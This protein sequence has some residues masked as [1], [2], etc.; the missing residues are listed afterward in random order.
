MLSLKPELIA[1]LDVQAREAI[2]LWGTAAQFNMVI[3]E[4][5]ELLNEVAKIHRNQ[6]NWDNIL[7]ES[8][9]TYIMMTEVFLMYDEALVNAMLEKKLT[10]FKANLE[11]SKAKKAEQDAELKRRMNDLPQ[12]AKSKPENVVSLFPDANKYSGA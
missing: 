11:R 9:D 3:E 6:Q 7:E 4:T 5:S 12:Y 1:Q 2:E 8:V 10:K